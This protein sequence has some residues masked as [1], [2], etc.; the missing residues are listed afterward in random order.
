VFCTFE[1]ASG[2][3]ALAGVLGNAT[4]DFVR[5]VCF[6]DFNQKQ[7]QLHHSLVFAPRERSHIKSIS[8]LLGCIF[9]LIC[10]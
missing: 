9:A 1:F 7:L 10:S 6:Q 8:S 5:L 2:L 4:I 3:R